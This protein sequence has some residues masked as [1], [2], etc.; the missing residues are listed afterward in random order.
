MVASGRKSALGEG[1]EILR[2]GIPLDL[3]RRIKP[4]K[5]YF[6]SFRIHCANEWVFS[7]KYYAIS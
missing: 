4:L 1:Q 2:N 7:F 5:T 3:N 6:S